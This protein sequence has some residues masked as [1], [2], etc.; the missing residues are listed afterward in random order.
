MKYFVISWECCFLQNSLFPIFHLLEWFEQLSASKIYCVSKYGP[1]MIKLAFQE[2]L[3]TYSKFLLAIWRESYDKKHLFLEIISQISWKCQK[4]EK[5]SAQ[6]FFFIQV[7]T[8]SA[9]TRSKSFKKLNFFLRSE[10]LLFH[11][12]SVPNS[13][14]PVSFVNRTTVGTEG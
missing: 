3:L 2:E 4:Q 8:F 11:L 9:K 10:K 14:I 6:K 13:T 12:C 5:L 1:Y 7:T